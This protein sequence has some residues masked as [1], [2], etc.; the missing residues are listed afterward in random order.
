VNDG[1]DYLTLSLNNAQAEYMDE[2]ADNDDNDEQQEDN[3][4]PREKVHNLGDG[5]QI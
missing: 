4:K 1:V 2:N 5:M 3:D